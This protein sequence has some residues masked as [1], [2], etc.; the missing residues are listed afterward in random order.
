MPIFHY[1]EHTESAGTAIIE[2]IPAVAG[3]IPRLTSIRYTAVTTAQTLKVMRTVAATT[4]AANAAA[5]Q[6]VIEFTDTGAMNLPTTGA[7][8]VIAAS[9]YV[10]YKTENGVYEYNS[11]ASVSGNNVTMNTNLAKAVDVGA[12]IYIL[13]ELARAVH[14]DWAIP[15]GENNDD[16]L[17]LQGGI[18]GQICP[19]NKRSGAGEPILIYCSNVTNAATQNALS[20]GYV[21]ASDV[22]IT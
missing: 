16:G 18:P 6:L 13:G 10:I 5:S 9:D 1:G 8:E 4:A 14:L 22:A 17:A 3:M 15:V 12:P 2:V 19:F 21:D 11:V 20:G 7:D